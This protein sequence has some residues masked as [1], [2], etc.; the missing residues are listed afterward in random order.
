MGQAGVD[1]WMQHTYKD[2]GRCLDSENSKWPK[3]SGSRGASDG[4]VLPSYICFLDLPDLCTYSATSEHAGIARNRA[5]RHKCS[6][7]E[8][9]PALSTGDSRVTVGVTLMTRREDV[10]SVFE[11][12]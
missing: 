3:S 2:V 4:D 9:F 6:N 5:A 8:G 7:I 10:E 1:L 12:G 11:V